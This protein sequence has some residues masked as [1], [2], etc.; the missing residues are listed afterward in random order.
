VQ[1][2]LNSCRDAARARA[3]RTRAR[4]NLDRARVARHCSKITMTATAD[5]SAPASR[6]ASLD[7]CTGGNNMLGVLKSC[8]ANV[9]PRLRPAMPSLEAIRASPHYPVVMTPDPS[10]GGGAVYCGDDDLTKELPINGEAIEW[11]N[12]LWKVRR[13]ATGAAVRR[14]MQQLDSSA[15]NRHF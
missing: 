14:G 10:Q 5:V 12:D 3:A 6:R 2:Q 7:A 13:I 1:Q 9:H 8:A 11:E 4:R 15:Q